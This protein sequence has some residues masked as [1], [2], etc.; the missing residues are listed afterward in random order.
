MVLSGNAQGLWEFLASSL[1][2]EAISEQQYLETQIDEQRKA[3]I[4]HQHRIS[5]DA[6]MSLNLSR[7]SVSRTLRN[8]PLA[9][10][11]WNEAQGLLHGWM[12]N[13]E[14]LDLHELIQLN[15]VL[16]DS[17]KPGWRHGDIHTTEIKHIDAD[18]IDA[19][20]EA[21][22]LHLKAVLRANNDIYAAFVCRYWILSI[23]P[24]AEAN[25]RTSQLFADFYLLR[26]GYLPQAFVSIMDAALIGEPKKRPYM[27][28]RL[29][30]RRFAK[31]I[32]N[33]YQLITEALLADKKRFFTYKVKS[34][35]NIEG[36]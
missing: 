5:R 7:A 11:K 3:L 9:M 18:E 15:A 10:A 8:C 24:F 27:D 25:G 17:S 4:A 31:T 30:F 26:S 33:A 22:F 1:T 32:L 20:M 35:Q 36:R 29:A 19:M 2:L 13:K 6:L 16:S 34:L 12:Q 28:P 14:R 21:F 23:H